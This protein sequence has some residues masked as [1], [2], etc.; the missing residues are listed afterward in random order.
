MNFKFILLFSIVFIV[1]LIE[2]TEGT[3]PHSNFVEKHTCTKCDVHQA[4]EKAKST[5]DSRKKKKVLVQTET[6]FIVNGDNDDIWQE[7]GDICKLKDAVECFDFRKNGVGVFTQ[8]R[9]GAGHAYHNIKKRGH[10][11]HG[12]S[13]ACD[14]K[15]KWISI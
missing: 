1:I 10:Y 14:N 7:H 11:E 15:G 3:C 2:H 8:Y 13:G 12:M 6:V 5:N 9:K 4:K